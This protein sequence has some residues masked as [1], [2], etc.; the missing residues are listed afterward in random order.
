MRRLKKDEE[1][2]EGIGVSFKPGIP[3]GSNNMTYHN[4]FPFLKSYWMGSRM[5]LVGLLISFWVRSRMRLVGLLISFWVRSRMRLVGLL[6]SYWVRSRMR[7]VG[8]LVI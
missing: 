7:L 8:I 5:R 1:A 3:E 2:Q 4:S 6:I